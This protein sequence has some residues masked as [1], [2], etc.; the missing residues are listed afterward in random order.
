MRLR[1]ARDGVATV[2]RLR[3][4]HERGRRAVHRRVE[5]V[6]LADERFARVE[7]RGVQLGVAADALDLRRFVIFFAK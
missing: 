5:V 3:A 4:R 7:D 2:G 6:P 1:R